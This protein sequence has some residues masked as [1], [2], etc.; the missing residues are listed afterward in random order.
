[1]LGWLQALLEQDETVEDRKPVRT[2]TALADN[3]NQS[4][5]EEDYEP[6]AKEMLVLLL[7]C[8]ISSLQF[9]KRP[10]RV[11]ILTVRR[12]LITS[13]ALLGT[14]LSAYLAGLCLENGLNRLI[15]ARF[16]SRV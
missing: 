14:T 10:P 13:H 8:P 12:N 7:I 11:P 4:E 3:S 15:S 1:M 2:L 6:L 9:D 5:D 16:G